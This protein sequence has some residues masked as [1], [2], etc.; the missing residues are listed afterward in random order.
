MLLLLLLL[1][2]MFRP[3]H[4]ADHVSSVADPTILHVT[5][6]WNR[7]GADMFSRISIQ[8]ILFVFNVHN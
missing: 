3:G 5:M 6:C 4:N 1:F 2:L 8:L 7:Q